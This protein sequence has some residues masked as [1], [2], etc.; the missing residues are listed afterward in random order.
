MVFKTFLLKY[1]EIGIKGKNRG[2]FE[3]ALVTQV[4]HAL[5]KVEGEYEVSKEQGRIYVN[6][7]GDDN[8]FDPDEAVEALQKVFGLVGICQVLKAPVADPDVIAEDAVR[9][10]AKTYGLAPAQGSAGA[11][12]EEILPDADA[13]SFKVHTRRAN[14]QYPMSSMEVDALVHARHENP[15]HILGM[16]ECIDDVYINVYLPD[17]KV[18]K[19]KNLETKKNYT[20]VSERVKGFALTD[21]SPRFTAS[22]RSFRLMPTVRLLMAD[23]VTC[24]SS[25]SFRRA[26]KPLS[27]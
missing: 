11:P 24:S 9:Y 21:T 18:V 5:S 23:A 25:T 7:Q 17:A 6:V 8:S 13:L 3:D 1:G 22:K 19:V 14:K 4:R 12:G 26:A 10:M 15:H 2:Q 16:H 20:L 27:R